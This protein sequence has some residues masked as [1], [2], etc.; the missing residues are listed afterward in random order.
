MGQRDFEDAGKSSSMI[1]EE[2]ASAPPN[3][4]EV[5]PALRRTDPVH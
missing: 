1:K 4:P 3:T 5:L 2:T